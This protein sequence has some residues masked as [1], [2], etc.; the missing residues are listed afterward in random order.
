MR[1]NAKINKQTDIFSS[2]LS[3]PFYA[4]YFK[5]EICRTLKFGKKSFGRFI[6]LASFERLMVVNLD[7][8]VINCFKRIASQHKKIKVLSS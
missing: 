5:F 2:W 6:Y 4:S 7:V 3:F 1:E 8:F